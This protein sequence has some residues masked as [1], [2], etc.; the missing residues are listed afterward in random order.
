MRTS[1]HQLRETVSYDSL[2]G[3]LRERLTQLSDRRASKSRYK[4]VDMLM[5]G[6]AMFS[7]KYAS[8]LQF[9]EQTGMERENL[10]HLYGIER[11]STDSQMRKVLD[12]V[13][14]EGIKALY[15]ENFGQLR[16]LGITKEYAC[17]KDYLVVAIDGVT[18]FES[19]HIH[20]KHCLEKHHKDGSVSYA[21]A[22][23]CAMLVKPGHKEV[24]VMGSE[25]II[26]QDGE[27]KND[28]ERN[29]SKRL[30]DWMGEHYQGQNLLLTEDAL[31]ATAPNITQITDN[32]WS[33]VLGIKPDGHKALFK[34]FDQKVPN[35]RA[36]T[37]AW[38]EKGIKHLFNYINNLPLNTA[39]P[40]V[41]VN[42]L[43]YQQ[44]DKQ[45]KTTRFS[46]V[47]NLRLTKKSV[48]EVM[49]IGRS[50][51]TMEPGGEHCHRR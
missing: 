30:L 29:A 33:Y 4:L 31:Y 20:C 36:K 22:M 35:Q 21:H 15:T 34:A 24:F 6:F 18:H 3:K 23:L 32:H 39:N 27:E 41:R 11:I 43:I 14:P 40:Q 17:Y 37:Y 7:L 50:R 45:G 28:C 5:S 25:A 13:D 42:V 26:C 1:Y 8:L 48:L 19:K 38:R 49:R 16:Q 9:E 10:H 44:T 47:T 2:I 46:W 12:K 51:W